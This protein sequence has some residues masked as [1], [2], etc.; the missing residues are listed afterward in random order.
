VCFIC[1]PTYNGMQPVNPTCKT[2]SFEFSQSFA[3]DDAK[4]YKVIVIGN[5]ETG[6]LVVELFHS[7]LRMLASASSLSDIFFGFHYKWG[8]DP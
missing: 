4:S 3:Q 1:T 5:D 7:E 2:T 8:P 6:R